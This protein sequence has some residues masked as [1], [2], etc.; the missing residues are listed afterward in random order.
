[1]HICKNISHETQVI[2]III[3]DGDKYLVKNLHYF[4]K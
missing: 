1:M 2:F 3:T 4:E